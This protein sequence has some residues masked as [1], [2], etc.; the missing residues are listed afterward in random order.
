MLNSW[1]NLRQPLRTYWI[2]S[3][4]WRLVCSRYFADTHN[5]R[6]VRLG[7]RLPHWNVPVLP[8]SASKKCNVAPAQVQTT[9]LQSEDT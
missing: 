8:K 2:E 4:P 9:F 5:D 6:G 7:A 1:L 3:G